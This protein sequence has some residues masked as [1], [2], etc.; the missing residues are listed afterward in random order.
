MTSRN[1]LQRSGHDS[2]MQL[3]PQIRTWPKDQWWYPSHHLGRCRST[4]GPS[5]HWTPAQ[6]DEA[7]TTILEL[8]LTLWQ[9]ETSFKEKSPSM[10]VAD[11]HAKNLDDMIP[12]HL[13]QAQW[14]ALWHI[15]KKHSILFSGKLGKLP[16]KPTP[17]PNI[18]DGEMSQ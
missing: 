14:W 18:R 3:D 15:L 17:M 10:L 9:A 16:C 12:T 7:F 6:I 11:Y 4:H 5:G 13:N 2:W 1:K 8:P